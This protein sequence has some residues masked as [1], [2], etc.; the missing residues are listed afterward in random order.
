MAAN[1]PTLSKKEYV[2]SADIIYDPTIRTTFSSLEVATRLIVNAVDLF[3]KINLEIRSLSLSDYILLATWEKEILLNTD[4][5]SFVDT[6]SV[7]WT[8]TLISPIKY[9]VVHAKETLYNVS[10]N[11]IGFET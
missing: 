1:F 2:W 5:F 7:T 11:F 3:Y 6:A 9:T 4:T 10:I 8:M